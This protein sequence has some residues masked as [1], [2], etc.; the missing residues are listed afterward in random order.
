[1]GLQ[2]RRA[3]VRG[4]LE[5]RRPGLAPQ[6]TA[7]QEG[8]VG[9]DGDLGGGDGLGGVPHVGEAAR[10]DL[11]VQLH[12]GAGGFGRDGLRGAGEVLHAVDVEGEVLAAGGHDLFVEQCVA[13]DVG[14]VGGDQVVPVE[15]RQNA[16]HHDSRIHLARFSVGICQR[17]PEFLR[18]TVEY[19]PAQRMWGYVDFQ[20]EHGEFCLEITA[21]DPLKDLRI[22]HFRHAV[23]AGQIQFD[24][25][26]HEVLGAIE[27]LLV[28]QPLQSRQAPP[29]LVAIVLPIGQVEPPCH[30]LLPH[31][32]VPPRIT[33]PTGPARRI[34]RRSRVTWDDAQPRRSITSPRGP[35]ARYSD[36][37]DRRHIRQAWTHRSFRPS[38][39]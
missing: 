26:P 38:T 16:D 36:E 22:E 33:G 15:S 14:E 17:R 6:L 2:L 28:Q 34:V 21:R 8:R 23:A 3:G 7:E 35:A 32:S 9:A 20:I 27:P 11:E 39:H 25:Q 37:S 31:R 29:E 18:E 19:A 5:E 24:L 12:G 4:L 13:V 30:D 10:G 1:M